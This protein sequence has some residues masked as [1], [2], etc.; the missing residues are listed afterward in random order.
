MV[1]LQWSVS[2]K[3]PEILIGVENELPNG[4]P[5]YGWERHPHFEQGLLLV[6][7]GAGEPVLGSHVVRVRR[8]DPCGKGSRGMG[9][10]EMFRRQ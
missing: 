1:L 3:K 7:V 5:M 8:G 10:I 4:T 2:I 6:Q 9:S